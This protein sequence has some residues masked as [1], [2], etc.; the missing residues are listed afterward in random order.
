MLDIIKYNLFHEDVSTGGRDVL[1]D[2]QGFNEPCK[3]HKNTLKISKERPGPASIVVTASLR[4]G[5]CQNEKRSLAK[6]I[7]QL[8]A[9]LNGER[10]AAN[11][12]AVST[13]QI[14]EAHL[15]MRP[16]PYHISNH[17]SAS[18]RQETID[19]APG[20]GPMPLAFNIQLYYCIYM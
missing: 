15:K 16:G 17:R 19:T 10:L 20:D 1:R 4:C 11:W 2:L 6:C 7:L 14:I 3:A 18:E 8:E 5:F 13:S 9:A 12:R